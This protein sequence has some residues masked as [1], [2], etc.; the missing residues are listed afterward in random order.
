MP[1]TYILVDF[2]NVQPEVADLSLIRG[3]DFRVLI[4]HGAHQN[5]LDVNMYKAL[6]PL[7]DKVQ[8]I[9]SDRQG[10]NALDSHIFFYLGRSLQKHVEDAVG[11]RF[12]VISKDTDFNSLIA[13]IR[14]LGFE[15]HRVA[16]IRSALSTSAASSPAPAQLPAKKT[17]AKK[18][19]AAKKA[20]AVKTTGKVPAVKPPG[21]PKASDSPKQ[22]VL[23]SLRRMG[24]KLPTKRKGLEHHIE[25][26]LGRKVGLDE[27]RELIAEMERDGA[28]LIL[29]NKVEYKLPKASK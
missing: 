21:T 19:S 6:Q 5:K 17:A 27:V 26:H 13:H 22:L 8:L 7:G 29:D 1:L 12:F 4:F 15:A 25:S 2:E 10:P 24:E 14:T 3:D 9:Q 20:P 28:L 11:A 18:T 23:A 16:T